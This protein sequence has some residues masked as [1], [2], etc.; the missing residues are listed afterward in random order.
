MSR[1]DGFLRWAGTILAVS[2]L[3]LALGGC[4]GSDGSAGA[5]GAAGPPGPVG[6]AGPPAPVPDFVAAAIESANVESCATCHSGVGDSH[7]AEYAKFADASTFTLTIDSVVT[8]PDGAGGF[9]LTMGFSISHNG[10]PFIDAA[11]LAPSVDMIGFYV[12]QYDSGTGEFANS[13]G[14]F[15]SLDAGLATS[16]GNGTYTLAQNLAYDVN[17]FGGG[18][19]VGKIG[20]GELDIEDK[21]YNPSVGKRVKMY[22]D[23]STDAFTVGDIGTYQSTA[24]VAGCESC[25]GAPYRKHGNYDAMIAGA[26]D[27]LYCKACHTDDR[28]GGSEQWQYM[29]DDPFGWATDVPATGDYAYQ[30]VLMNDV[31]MSHA[32]EF[33]YPQSMAN[34]A[35]C[36]EG[37]LAQ[38]TDD[39]LFTADTCQSCHV[40]QG[41]E[42]WPEDVGTTLEGQYAQPH[43]PPPLEFL[44]ARAGVEGFHDISVDCTTCHEPVGAVAPT[45]AE[46][47]NGYDDN[48]YDAAGQKYSDL[49]TVSVDNVTMSGDLMTVNF[50][51]S[52]AAIV[53]QLMVSFYGWDSKNFI[54]GAHE[55]DG[56]AACSGY[57][58]GCK[59]EYVPESSGGSAN[60]LFAED[61]ASVPGNW[62]VTLDTSA[63]QLT[64]TDLIPQLIADGAIKYAEVTI[65]PELD[66][67]GTDA[68]LEAVSETFDIGGS[69]M[70]A[71][72]FQGA[73]AVVDIDKCNACHDT[74]A[75][76]FHAG[77]GR[78]G[79]SMQVCKTCHTTTF[80]GGH[81]EMASRSIDSYVHAIHTFQPFDEDDVAAADDPVFDARNAQH[82]SHVF[83]YFTALACEGCHLPGTYNVPDQSKSMPGVLAA[84]WDI[85]D[86]NIGTVPEVVTGPASRACGA[87]HRAN[88]I[89]EDRAGD[90]AS[91]NAHTDAF[92]TL[93]EN[94]DEDMILFGIIDKI[95]SLFQ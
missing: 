45:F 53:P 70:V 59:M 29:V 34:C 11:G 41:I 76:T 1:F 90:L 4:E 79:D 73:N 63:L 92:G 62:M 91:F 35:T 88:M 58:P 26:P 18:A 65:T 60:P 20:V 50:S 15:P 22:A 74:L 12:I 57:R 30:A 31:H 39:A 81:L 24:N 93:E 68:V 42:A 67:G 86:R 64:K 8:A 71:D 47:H 75:S 6:P 25:H 43:R 51:S 94:D 10:A 3:A 38:V 23:L 13:G 85:N 87:C 52:D 80:P 28:N 56:N 2:T 48:I 9:N 61:A 36:H 82:K 95:M 32:M 19:I 78:G 89:I 5:A 16:N 17:A 46:Y 14:Y 7:Y 37:K 83:P 77:S 21:Q 72:Y 69:I 49:Y 54:V 33:P 66:L 44:W 84:S 27:F 55:R 40:L